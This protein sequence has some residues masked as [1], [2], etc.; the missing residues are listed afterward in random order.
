MQG[1]SVNNTKMVYLVNPLRAA[2]ERRQQGNIF[3]MFLKFAEIQIL[4]AIFGFS[5]KNAFKRVQTRLVLVQGFL[6]QLLEV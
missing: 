2:V 4:I 1:T 3:Q 6:W 5:T